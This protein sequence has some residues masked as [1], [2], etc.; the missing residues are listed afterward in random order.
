MTLE[1]IMRECLTKNDSLV[2]YISPNQKFWSQTLPQFA[3]FPESGNEFANVATLR[4]DT[5][6][7]INGLHHSV[8]YRI[9]GREWQ[10]SVYFVSNI[11]VKCFSSVV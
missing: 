7:V 3:R 5:N 6:H 1:N 10:E 4:I 2:A 8:T 11:T 9:S